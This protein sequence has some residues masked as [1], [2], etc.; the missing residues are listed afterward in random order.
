MRASTVLCVALL[1]VAVY[2]I[3][4]TAPPLVFYQP[5]TDIVQPPL[6]NPEMWELRWFLLTDQTDRVG[7]TLGWKCI[8]YAVTLRTEAT[9]QGYD[10]DVVLLDFD[11]TGHAV[12]GCRLSDGRYVWVEPQTDD[13]LEPLQVGQVY[14]LSG[15]PVG[16]ITAVR[17]VD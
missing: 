7:E 12:N 16:T 17:V 1:L 8:D 3:L 5:A 13:I 4:R 14:V 11:S 10:F 2:F 6:R 15:R 9:K